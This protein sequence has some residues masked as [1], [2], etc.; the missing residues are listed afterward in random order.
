MFWF[1]LVTELF[2]WLLTN[3]E[4]TQVNAT[5]ESSSK[6][7]EKK[8]GSG[9]LQNYSQT[10]FLHIILLGHWAAEQ[11]TECSGK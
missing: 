11:E 5:S 4:K 6:C 1:F 7:A 8:K 2:S 9:Y 3:C 10:I